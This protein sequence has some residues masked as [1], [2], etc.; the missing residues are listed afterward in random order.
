LQIDYA[1]VDAV[2]LMQTFPEVIDIFNKPICFKSANGLQ[3]CILEVSKK[4][5][6]PYFPPSFVSKTHNGYGTL[7][8]NIIR[9]GRRFS[10][11]ILKNKADT[12]MAVD[13]SDDFWF[14][15]EIPLME[16]EA[17]ANMAFNVARHMLEDD[18]KKGVLIASIAYAVSL[19]TSLILFT[20]IFGIVKGKIAVE[21]H[22]NRGVLFMVPHGI[23][24]NNK[25]MIEYIETLYTGI[26]E[27]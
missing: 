1:Y 25:A 22:Y 6:G 12:T 15:Y 19:G 16:G 11:D 7:V 5:G 17:G 13:S 9:S 8:Q 14:L 24:R 20:W 26:T 4:A 2:K 18:L 3:R 27:A 21:T 23:L 10:A